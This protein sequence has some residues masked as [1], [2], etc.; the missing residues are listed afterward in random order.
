MKRKRF[1]CLLLACLLTFGGSLPFSASAASAQTATARFRQVLALIE[2]LDAATAAYYGV[3]DTFGYTVRYLRSERYGDAAW[4]WMVGSPDEAYVSAMAPYASLRAIEE[5]QVLSGEPGRVVDFTHLAAAAD[6]RQDFAGWAGDLISLAADIGTLYE[7]RLLLGGEI[8][9]FN[10]P[11]YYADIDACNLLAY[12]DE[13]GGGLAAAM[14]QYYVEGG[15]THAVTD[16]LLRETGLAAEELTVDAIE[17]CFLARLS[18]ETCQPETLLLEGMYGL[19]GD[20]RLGY[21]CR[22]FAERLYSG[23]CGETLGHREVTVLT[24]E[25]TCVQRGYTCK[26]CTRCGAVWE[27]DFLPATGH[28]YALIRTE[29]SATLPGIEVQVCVACG[30][31]TETYFDVLAPGDLNGDGLLNAKDYLLLKRGI[32]QTCSLTPRQEFLADLNGDG[33]LD[34]LDYLLLRNSLLIE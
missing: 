15:V 30:Q 32:L 10:L 20:V 4:K 7:A 13:N 14:R 6:A 22:A 11:D 19:A 3:G 27:T 2:Q 12:A 33:V 8:G 16:F 31:Y 26:L 24:V 21:V 34:A 23:Y 1:L 9:A 5:L 18:G 29:P 28:R 17:A 25:P